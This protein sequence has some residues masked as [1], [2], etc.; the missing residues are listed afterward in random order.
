MNWPW[1]SRQPFICQLTK[2]AAWHRF[3]ASQSTRFCHWGA[4]DGAF[5]SNYIIGV[6]GQ[7]KICSEFAK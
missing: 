6:L 7:A 3:S 4:G 1:P 5:R 2:L